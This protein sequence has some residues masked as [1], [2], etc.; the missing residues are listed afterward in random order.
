MKQAAS[1]Q[2]RSP[3]AIEI[4]GTRLRSLRVPGPLRAWLKRGFH[5]MLQIQT[6][7]RGIACALPHGE[8][9]RVLPAFR[10]MA[11]NQAEYSAFR[12]AIKPGMVALD[13][14]ANIGAYSLLLGQWVKP[15]GRVYAF[16]PV[17]AV[18]YAL[19]R[20]IALNRLEDVITPV[21]QAVNDRS[22]EHSFVGGDSIGAGRLSIPSDA[23]TEM[24]Q[25]ECTTIDLFCAEKMIQPDFIKIDVEGFEALVLR[26]GRNT[27]RALKSSHGLFVEL[28]PTTW[29]NIGFKKEDFLAELDS[30]GIAM[31]P[32]DPAQNPWEVEGVCVRL[33][34]KSS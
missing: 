34:P 6:A 11:W 2:G 19:R 20:H 16:E 22:G 31:Q 1:F 12:N 7:G 13:I 3:T 5:S 8:Q 32:L 21:A 26:G 9:V 10:Y 18:H 28:H 33:I 17:P 27:I 14:G 24:E 25:V 29:Q 15:N 4:V 23:T 30:L